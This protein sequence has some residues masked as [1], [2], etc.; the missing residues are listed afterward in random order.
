[1][2]V[3][4]CDAWCKVKYAASVKEIMPLRCGRGRQA[5]NMPFED[6]MRYYRDT[7]RISSHARRLTIALI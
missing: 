6:K 4:C 1:M 3:P 5:E 2:N 7:L